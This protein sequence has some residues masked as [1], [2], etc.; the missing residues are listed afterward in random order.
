MKWW[1]CSLT[2]LFM[3]SKYFIMNVAA[4]KTKKTYFHSK[5]RQTEA[6]QK[7]WQQHFVPVNSQQSVSRE[8]SW[9][10]SPSIKYFLVIFYKEWKCSNRGGWKAKTGQ[11]AS[12]Q[13][14]WSKSNCCYPPRQLLWLFFFSG[15]FFF[16]KIVVFIKK[17]KKPEAHYQNSMINSVCNLSFFIQMVIDKHLL[18]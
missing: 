12:V 2:T 1:D 4:K 17:K 14:G 15:G 5:Q 18:K 7:F 9:D 11:D 10:D 13:S 6:F 8:I 3:L 16:W